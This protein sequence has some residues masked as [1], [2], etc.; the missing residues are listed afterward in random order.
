M[1]VPAPGAARYLLGAV[2]MILTVVAP[3]ALIVV[4]KNAAGSLLA[5]K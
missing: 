3:I 5:R 2:V 1:A 4:K